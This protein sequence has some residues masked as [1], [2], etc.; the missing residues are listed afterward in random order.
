MAKFVAKKQQGVTLIEL[1]IVVIVIGVIAG[2]AYPGYTKHIQ[3]TRQS[4][5][6]GELM[7]LASKLEQYR[8]KRFSY[9]GANAQLA[10][11]SPTLASSEFFTV[12]IS[13]TGAGS[14]SYELT[15]TPKAS[16]MMKGT[17][18]LKIDSEGQ[19]C[20]KKGGCTL[21]SSDPKWGD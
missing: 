21:G 8:A 1:M 7:N 3:E 5:V 18:V 2:I 16:S 19:T 14:Q 4:E 6:Q 17:E 13:V 11:L 9:D 15:A 12:A 20:M 10:T